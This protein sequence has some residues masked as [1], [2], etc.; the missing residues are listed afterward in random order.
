MTEPPTKASVD[1]TGTASS[2][3]V[4]CDCRFNATR[5]PNR[6]TDPMKQLEDK[7]GQT[8]TGVFAA[9]IFA[10]ALEESGSAAVAFFATAAFFCGTA[11]APLP[12]ED[13]E[14]GPD[15]QT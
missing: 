4:A 9:R 6:M 13:E 11:A 5:R 14:E 1:L 3:C 10:G 2:S 15:S 7:Q 12:P 8:D